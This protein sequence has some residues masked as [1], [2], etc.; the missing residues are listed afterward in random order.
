VAP[1]GNAPQQTSDN[2]SVEGLVDCVLFRDRFFMNHILFAKKYGQH[3]FYL[4][5]LQTKLFGLDVNFEV[6]SML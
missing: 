1:S 6:P 3:D 2:L 4:G 5:L